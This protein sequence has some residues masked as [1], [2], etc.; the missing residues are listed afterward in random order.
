MM[1][2]TVE[3]AVGHGTTGGDGAARLVRIERYAVCARVLV[4]EQRAW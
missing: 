3:D 2:L 4:R 1:E